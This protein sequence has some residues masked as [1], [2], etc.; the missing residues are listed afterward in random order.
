MIC[1]LTPALYTSAVSIRLPPASRYWSS[2]ACAPT[3]SVSVPN[4]IV[5]NAN[6]DTTAPLDPSMRYS[7]RSPRRSGAVLL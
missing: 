2:C 5:P 3:S 4:V 6:V 1:S 7:I